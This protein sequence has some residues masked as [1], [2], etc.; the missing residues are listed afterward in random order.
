MALR[1]LRQW[2]SRLWGKVFDGLHDESGIRQRGAAA[3][4]D[5]DAQRLG[6]F[7]LGCTGLE[8]LLDMNGDAV[9]ARRADRD[10]QRDRVP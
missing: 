2:Q 4:E 5:R 10:P 9:I 3:H 7:L 8:A 6:D 1:E